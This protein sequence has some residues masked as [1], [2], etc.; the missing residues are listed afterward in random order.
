[1]RLISETDTHEIYEE[2]GD[3]FELPKRSPKPGAP[4]PE[5]KTVQNSDLLPDFL[6]L[7]RAHNPG[8]TWGLTEPQIDTSNKSTLTPEKSRLHT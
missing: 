6:A 5:P 2:F 7:V 1:M 4:S 3:V 8:C